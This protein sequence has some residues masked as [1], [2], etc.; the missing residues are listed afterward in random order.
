MINFITSFSEEGYC[1]YARKMLEGVKEFWGKGI[2]LTAFYHD[3]DIK[4]YDYPK[5]KILLIGI[6]TKWKT[7]LPFEK[8]IKKMMAR[9]VERLSTTGE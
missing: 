2:H 6:L 4:D 9:W 5:V 8:R 7:C 3:F 1:T